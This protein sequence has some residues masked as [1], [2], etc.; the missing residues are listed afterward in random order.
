M[1]TIGLVGGIASGKSAVSAALARRGAVVFDADKIGHR[2][3]NEP[4]TRD[5]LVARW[6]QSILDANHRVSRAGVAE[7]VFGGSPEA[8]GERD[9]L[10]QTLHPRIR[11]R[12]LSEINQLPTGSAPAVVID[13]PLLIEAGWS[14]VCQALIFVDAP[15]Q[16]RLQRAKTRGWT[17]EEFSRREAAQMPI[18]EKRRRASHVIDNSGSLADLETEVDRFWRTVIG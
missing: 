3:L 2:V 18:E 12:I 7:R 15:R 1:I 10:E 8:A 6:G 11:Q 16:T 4:A 5:E 13:A 17:E 14:Q 9:F